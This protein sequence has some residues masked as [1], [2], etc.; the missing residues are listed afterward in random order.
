MAP[1]RQTL[2]TL[3]KKYPPTAS[4]DSANGPSD[5]TRPFL[6][7]TVLALFSPRGPGREPCPGRSNA[8]TR[9]SI[10]RRFLHFFGRETLL[11]VVAAEQEHVLGRF[12]CSAHICLS[13][14]NY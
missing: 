5:T 1:L 11:P 12:V 10:A 8:R 3:S 4:F 14:I 7:E 6:P 2:F 9:P 13:S